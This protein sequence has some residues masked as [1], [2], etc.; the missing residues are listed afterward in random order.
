MKA[1]RN[2]RASRASWILATGLCE[3]NLHIFAK[4]F[5]DRL[6]RGLEAQTRP[7]ASPPTSPRLPELCSEGRCRAQEARCQQKH[8]ALNAMAKE[9]LPALHVAALAKNPLST[10]RLA[11]VRNATGLASACPLASRT[12]KHGAVLL[13]GPRRWE[14]AG[15]RHWFGSASTQRPQQIVAHAAIELQHAR[16]TA[17]AER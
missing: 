8:C 9:Q 7:G 2:A 13:N 17:R 15:W 12:M 10:S 3:P 16:A 1:T 4:Q 14:A 11:S 5:E 6:E